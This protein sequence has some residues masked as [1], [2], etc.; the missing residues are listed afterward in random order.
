MLFYFVYSL[1]K[2]ARER[3]GRPIY[4]QAISNMIQELQTYFSGESAAGYRRPHEMREPAHLYRKDMYLRRVNYVHEQATP[5]SKGNQLI[6]F[7]AH[8]QSISSLTILFLFHHDFPFHLPHEREE[9]LLINFDIAW[10]L[11]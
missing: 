4:P 1:R 9:L 2:P 8:H 5:I 10:M 3:T 6:F 7:F 11:S